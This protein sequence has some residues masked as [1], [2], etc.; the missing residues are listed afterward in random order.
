MKQGC[1]RY[2]RLEQRGGQLL[3][4]EDLDPLGESNVG[5]DDRGVV[6]VPV[7]QEVEEPLA[8]G[9]LERHEAEF[10][11]DQQGDEQVAQVLTRERVFIEAVSIE[12]WLRP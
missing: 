4:A 2:V 6:L 3:V 7:G 12:Q 11:D 10:V 5:I 1:L 9:P 8:L